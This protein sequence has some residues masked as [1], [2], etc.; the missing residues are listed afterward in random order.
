MGLAK[1][2]RIVFLPQL[3]LHRLS[4]VLLRF[5]RHS[6]DLDLGRRW[7]RV[8][9]RIT[10]ISGVVNIMRRHVVSVSIV[11]WGRTCSLGP[12]WSMQDQSSVI[13]LTRQG[14]YFSTPASSSPL[15][16]LISSQNFVSQFESSCDII[17]PCSPASELKPLPQKSI[18]R[19]VNDQAPPPASPQ[20]GQGGEGLFHSPSSLLVNPPAAP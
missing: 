2:G 3:L 12:A 1:Q 9:K 16:S 5:V 8:V 11:D 19:V 15:G 4:P 10:S 6:R 18:R 7:V 14:R 17:L 20:S 13:P